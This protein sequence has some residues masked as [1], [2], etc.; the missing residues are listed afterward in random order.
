MQNSLIIHWNYNFKTEIVKTKI[1][2]F[3]PNKS[4]GDT[5]FSKNLKFY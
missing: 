1:C 2:M 3:K 4:F 5:E